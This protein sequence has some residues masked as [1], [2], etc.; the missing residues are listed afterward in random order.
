MI[1]NTKEGPIL[2]SILR[3]A[4]GMNKLMAWRLQHLMTN[5]AKC[6]NYTILHSLRS[7]WLQNNIMIRLV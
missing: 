4:L 6:P 2:I 1:C 5:S 3:N 7:S